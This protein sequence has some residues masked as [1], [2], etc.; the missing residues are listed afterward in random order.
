MVLTK[1]GILIISAPNDAI[2]DLDE[3][4][5]PASPFRIKEFTAEELTSLLQSH[6]QLSMYGQ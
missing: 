1:G 4:G 6:F 3:N 2:S 5:K